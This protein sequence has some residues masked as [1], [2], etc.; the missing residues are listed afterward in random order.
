MQHN[1]TKV[2]LS[3]DEWD[4]VNNAQIL[5]TKNEIIKKVYA[6]FGELAEEYSKAARTLPAEVIHKYPKISRGENY[7]G[8]PY[9]MLDYPRHFL[10][11]DTLAIRTFFWWGNFFSITIQL[12]G[13]Y[14]EMLLAKFVKA[15][16]LNLLNDWYVGINEDKWRHDFS[17]ANYARQTSSDLKNTM[18]KAETLKLAK[19]IPLTEWDGATYFLESNFKFLLSIIKH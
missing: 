16:E 3:K 13:S 15:A 8:L 18:Q 5:L 11:E 2:S 17:E 19:K 4:L 10:K 6:L 14:R 1:L 9:V 12:S 7:E